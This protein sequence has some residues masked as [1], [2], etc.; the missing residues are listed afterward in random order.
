MERLGL[1]TRIIEALRSASILTLSDLKRCSPH[2]LAMI[3]NIGR[4]RVRSILS[5][6]ANEP[7]MTP[8]TLKIEK[9]RKGILRHQ[10]AIAE[11]EAEIVRLRAL[12]IQDANDSPELD[13]CLKIEQNDLHKAA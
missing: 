3:P 4:D 10:H 9:L 8:I 12:V 6:L 11:A 13:A 1:D 2:E 7:P 5:A